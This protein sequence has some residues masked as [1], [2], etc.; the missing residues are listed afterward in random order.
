MGIAWNVHVA[1]R[2]DALEL[3]ADSG[4][5]PQDD[6]AYRGFEHRVDQAIQRDVLVARRPAVES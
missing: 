1:S 3:L 4:L 6:E 2:D 5:E